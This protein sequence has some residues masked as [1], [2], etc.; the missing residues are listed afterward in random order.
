M[1]FHVVTD[2][3]PLF[4]L[5]NSTFSNVFD[6][7]L[8]HCRS[9]TWKE[10]YYCRRPDARSSR[11]TYDRGRSAVARRSD[12]TSKPGALPATEKRLT[13]IR[14]RHL[15]DDVCRLVIRYCAEGWP[16][17][18]SLPSVLRP[19]WQVQNDLTIQNG[20][21]LKGVRLV[22]PTFTRLAMQDKLHEGHQGVVRCRSQAQ[23]SV[24][25]TGLSRQ[26]GEL[27]RSCT[28]CAVE[29]RN[30]SE[31]MIASDT[32]LRPWQ[33]TGT[34]MFVYKKATYLLAVAYASSYVEIA[35]LAA[36]TSPDANLHLKS[37]FA[38]HVIPETVVSDNGPQYA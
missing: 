14:A 32:V 11:T 30:Q 21:L 9:C 17:H 35:K 20:L 3:K 26:L 36:T 24:W 18:P 6:A 15:E 16:S 12:G 33:N 2:H 4:S 28:A 37:I 23:S 19:Y 27:V 1:S 22:I 34:Y 31:P 5:L 13:E 7:I 10:T 29:R 25:W 38:R 8:V